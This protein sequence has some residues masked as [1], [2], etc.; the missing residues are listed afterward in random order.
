MTEQ[1]LDEGEIRPGQ[2]KTFNYIQ[3]GQMFI[4]DQELLKIEAKTGVPMVEVERQLRRDFTGLRIA[5]RQDELGILYIQGK[6]I[7]D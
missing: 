1:N 2:D 5:E 7:I 4:G 6:P 3:L